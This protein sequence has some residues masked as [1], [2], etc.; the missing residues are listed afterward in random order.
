MK[1]ALDANVVIAGLVFRGAAHRLLR[2]AF[3]GTHEFTMSEDVRDEVLEVLEE[4]FPR[5][6]REA[7]EAL[8]I[9]PVA[10]VPKGAYA[11]RIRDFPTLR[12]PTDAHVLAAA[13]EIECDIL[14]TWDKDLL[15]FGNAGDLRI[16]AP[17]EALHVLSV[18]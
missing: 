17:V 14:V 6:R 2:M 12:D 1:V 7:E 11:P 4:K 16:V 15:S 5:L 13:R 3:S 8:S 18:V 10:V 9:L